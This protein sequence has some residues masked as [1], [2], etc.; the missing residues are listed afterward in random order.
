MREERWTVLVVTNGKRT[1]P[2]YFDGFKI[3][4]R[5]VINHFET[6][7]LNA[8]PTALV[9]LAAQLRDDSDHNE[10]WVVCDVDEFDVVSA[11]RKADNLNVELALSMPS[12]EVWL[13]LHLRDGCPGF[14]NAGQAVKFLQSLLPGW[15]K[16]DLNFADFKNAVH[17]AVERAQRLG[18][19]PEANPSTAVWRLIIS[20]QTMHN[21]ET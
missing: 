14:N 21:S 19:P 17:R 9:A 1:E 13:I 7:F 12:F 10:V 16:E 20:L 15:T 2:D 3:A 11:Q 5:S 6:R 4:Y 8:A 18:E